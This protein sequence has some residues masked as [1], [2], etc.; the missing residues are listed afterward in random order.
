MAVERGTDR[1]LN[2]IVFPSALGVGLA[3]LGIYA[4]G[5]VAA[6]AV[7]EAFFLWFENQKLSLFVIT[8]ISQFLAFGLLA[9]FV[10][11]IIGRVSKRW[12]LSC[13]VGYT[14]FL[15]TVSFGVAQFYGE[16]VM[17]PFAGATL[18]GYFWLESLIVPCCLMLTARLFAS[19]HRFSIRR[20]Y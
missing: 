13:L 14:T 10:G 2:Q 5:Y 16:P 8:F 6:I 18:G 20:E 19:R 11:S 4:M 15:L 7:P 3:V 12:L 1:F 17:L 9:L